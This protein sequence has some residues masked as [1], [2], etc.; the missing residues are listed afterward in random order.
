MM[1]H[2]KIF[3][4]ILFYTMMFISACFTWIIF[5]T[6][7]PYNIAVMNSLTVPPVVTRGIETAYTAD[8]CKYMSIPAELTVAIQ[9]GAVYQLFSQTTSLSV[10]CHISIRP[11][12]VPEFLEAGTYRIHWTAI[13]KPNI[14]RTVT[15]D[16]YSNEFMVE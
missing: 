3:S 9:N 16:A 6:V 13:Y 11:F 2:E 12:T 15:L 5:Q 7:R 4:R 8:A 1:K 14:F 10:G